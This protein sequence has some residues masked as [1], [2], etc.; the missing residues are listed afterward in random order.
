M[1]VA[2]SPTAVPARAPRALTALAADTAAAPS[3]QRAPIEVVK[4]SSRDLQW[5]PAL[6]NLLIDNVHQ[7]ATVG[8]LAPLSRYAALDY[9]HGVFARLGQHHS[10]WIA[11]ESD[12]P[13][14]LLGAV[15]L[16][17]CPLANAHHR[18]EVQR[19]MV[20]TQERGRGVASQLMSRLECTAA[21]QNRYLLQLETAADSQAEA[22]FAHLGWQRAGQIPDHCHGAEGQLQSVAIYYKRLPHL[23]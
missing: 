19:L 20:H 5:L 7:G 16:S 14:R 17:L 11:C 9:W 3:L 10:L 12:G 23:V 1:Y 22:V 2:L 15:Q 18:G 13:G 4:L 6:T 8:F 21:T